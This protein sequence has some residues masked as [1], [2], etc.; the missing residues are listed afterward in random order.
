MTTKKELPEC[1]FEQWR[2]DDAPT[3][4]AKKG[5]DT[6]TPKDFER[7]VLLLIEDWSDDPEALHAQYDGLCE[8]VLQETGFGDG[9]ALMQGRERWYA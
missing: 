3:V 8:Q 7:A 2:Q 6:M 1:L 4:T 5:K 9:V